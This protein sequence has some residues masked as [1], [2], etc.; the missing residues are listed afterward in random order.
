MLLSSWLFPLLLLSGPFFV[1]AISRLEMLFT[2]LWSVRSML[3]SRAIL[4]LM[5]S[6][7]RVLLFGVSLILFVRL[8][9]PLVP[10][11]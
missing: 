2:Y 10:A 3:F 6:T 1:S 11:A 7:L 4:L 9:V 5:S 8:C